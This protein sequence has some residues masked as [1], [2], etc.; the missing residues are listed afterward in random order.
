MNR[1]NALV[2]VMLLMLL[3]TMGG[4]TPSALA[5]Q[6][7]ERGD[8]TATYRILVEQRAKAVVP[9]RYVITLT[10]GGQEQRNEDRTQGVLV[11]ADGLVLVPARA[12]SLDLSALGRAPPGAGAEARSSG[13]RVRLPGS[14][15]WRDADL[16]TRDSE[17]GLAWL[18]VR[19]ASGLPFID[20]N[21]V[22]EPVPGRRF[23][24][25]LRTSD[26]WGAVPVVRP[27][28]VL[29]ETRVPRR[30]LLVDGMPGL[31]FDAAGLP[32]GF[33]DI[34]LA[35]MSRAQG[36]GLGLDLADLVM[37]MLPA[38]RV[39]AATRLAETLPVTRLDAPAGE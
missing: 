34:D 31:A 27:G 26:E 35:A 11:S 1:S 10:A 39:A 24:T 14:D 21:E 12:I 30:T 32:M 25:L 16:V 9:V 13:F 22:A 38:R 3:T 17:L 6:T 37:H 7:L 23:Y 20:F 36:R 8:F 29:G 33:V 19:E 18:R 4:A 28:M 2:R 15:E 5:N